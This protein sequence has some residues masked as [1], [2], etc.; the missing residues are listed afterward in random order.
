MRMAVSMEGL[1]P[2][3]T[4]V[5]SPTFSPRFMAW[6]TRKHASPVCMC[7]KEA[8]QWQDNQDVCNHLQGCM[9]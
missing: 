2:P 3:A 1:I 7:H 9:A 8:S 6:L 5:P 4:S